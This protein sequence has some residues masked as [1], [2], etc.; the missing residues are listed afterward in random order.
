MGL[1]DSESY[2]LSFYLNS[3]G[4]PLSHA[5]KDIL[6]LAFHFIFIIALFK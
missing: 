1:G 6:N 2:L 3:H 4:N 5:M